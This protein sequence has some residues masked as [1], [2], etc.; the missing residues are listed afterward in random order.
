MFKYF[1]DTFRYALEAPHQLRVA[2]V[3]MSFLSSHGEVNLSDAGNADIPSLVRLYLTTLRRRFHLQLQFTQPIWDFAKRYIQNR[4]SNPDIRVTKITDVDDDRIL[5]LIIWGTNAQLNNPYNTSAAEHGIVQQPS[6]DL[7]ESYMKEC[8]E[9]RR[10]YM[11]MEH[12]CKF[13]QRYSSRVILLTPMA[14]LEAPIIHPE[15]QKRGMGMAFM[16]H[17]L[18]EIDRQGKVILKSTV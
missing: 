5:G 14:V 12:I 16:R 11:D 2:H 1:Y 9:F 15:Y 18:E 3:V 8:F 7:Y 10:E 4:I 6:G 17:W 13:S